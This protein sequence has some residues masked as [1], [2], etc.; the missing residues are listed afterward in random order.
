MTYCLVCGR[1]AEGDP[2]F[3]PRCGRELRRNAENKPASLNRPFG[4]ELGVSQT[5][6]LSLRLYRRNFR[7]YFPVFVIAGAFLGI[8]YQASYNLFPYELQQQQSLGLFGFLEPPGTL[9]LSLF[10]TIVIS[11]I[12]ALT[13]GIGYA[14]AKDALESE[15]GN[16]RISYELAK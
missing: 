1:E 14:L 5:F 8:L 11:P 4:R 16:L 10:D 7:D 13:S 3:C 2:Q 6:T 12:T 15:H 9:L